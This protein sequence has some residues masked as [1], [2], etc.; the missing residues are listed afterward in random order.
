MIHG[1]YHHKK[2]IEDPFCHFP[3]L[4]DELCLASFPIG[5]EVVEE[6]DSI[7]LAVRTA[8]CIYLFTELSLAEHLVFPPYL[9]LHVL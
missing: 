1:V 7:T 9:L 2:V 5:P 8:D 3:K 4:I 6:L